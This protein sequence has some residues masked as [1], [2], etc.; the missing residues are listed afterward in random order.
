MPVS[1][2]DAPRVAM[3]QDGRYF[4]DMTSARA[5]DLVAQRIKHA[6][7]QHAWTAKDLAERCADL[8]AP[9]ISAA[10]IANIETGRRDDDGNRRRDVSIDEVLILAL[11]LEVPPAFLFV[12][13]NGHDELQVTPTRSMGAFTAAAWVDGAD[14]AIRSLSGQPYPE[15]PEDR[16]RWAQWRR[17]ARPLALLRNIWLWLADFDVVRKAHPEA[18]A[19][20][21]DLT[22]E[23]VQAVARLVEWLV[24]L[25]YTPPPLPR[26]V[27]E[28]IRA[29]GML[30]DV[31]PDELLILDDPVQSDA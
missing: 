7:T 13:L 2:Q 11:A 22:L 28:R 18:W 10:V 9:E 26:D 24:S 17:S 1:L 31:S 23:P 19:K 14:D 4:V 15:S 25:G 30:E 29:E 20:G 21:Y 5:S 16:E 3:R 27:I 8:G 12:P 6:R